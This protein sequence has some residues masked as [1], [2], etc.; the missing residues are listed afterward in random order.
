MKKLLLYLSLLFIIISSGS[1]WL[2]NRSKNKK[3]ISYVLKD[4]NEPVFEHEG[5]LFFFDEISADTLSTIDIE[6]VEKQ[7]EIVK[8]LMYRNRMEPA[9]GMFFIFREEKEQTFW[10]KNT[11]IPLDI[12][13]V[14]ADLKI[15]HIAKYTIPFSK[16]PIP[17]VYP[18]KYVIEVNAGFSN[19]INLKTGDHVVYN[20]ITDKKY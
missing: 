10:M 6:I 18:A 15:V 13:F 19:N 1:V 9:R 3:E 12:I 14:N 4:Y 20:M 11:K 16:E 17:S 2:I 5:I 7:E 8:G